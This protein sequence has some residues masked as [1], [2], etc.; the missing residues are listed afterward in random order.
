MTQVCTLWRQA[1]PV[2][3][4]LLARTACVTCATCMAWHLHHDTQAFAW[5]AVYP[6]IESMAL[7]PC[8]AWQMLRRRLPTWLTAP[9]HNVHGCD[10][11]HLWL[12]HLMLTG[13]T[14]VWLLDHIDLLT[15]TAAL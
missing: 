9:Q 6:C 10:G 1:Q 11:V 13:L 15:L 5:Q 4:L 8:P 2:Y 3:C 7:L 12:M 14:G